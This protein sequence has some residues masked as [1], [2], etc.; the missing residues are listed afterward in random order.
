M[1]ARR[2][3]N[4]LN[5]KVR[6]DTFMC[7]VTE[8]VLYSLVYLARRLSEPLYTCLQ[9]S[10]IRYSNILG[11]LFFC[12]KHSVEVGKIFDRYQLVM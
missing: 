11:V 7:D 10:L 1:V 3:H 12:L 2:A 4:L 6:G 9:S 5:I 8:T